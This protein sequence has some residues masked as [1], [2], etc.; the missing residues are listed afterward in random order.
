MK[1]RMLLLVA[2]ASLASHSLQAKSCN[3]IA[4][5]TKSID[6]AKKYVTKYKHNHFKDTK[7]LKNGKW[8]MISVAEENEEMA[9]KNI[10]KWKKQRKIP[11]DSKYSCKKYAEYS[12]VDLKKKPSKV[13]EN[14]VKIYPF[15]DKINVKIKEYLNE[16]NRSLST[17]KIAEKSLNDI[18][19]TP[20]NEGLKIYQQQIKKL[21]EHKNQLVL[22]YYEIYNI[23]VENKNDINKV[24]KGNLIPSFIE[25]ERSFINSIPKQISIMKSKLCSS[26]KFTCGATK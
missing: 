7:V 13:K 14:K 6:D 11:K 16:K 24:N 12:L 5:S 3:I 18:L 25:R 19:K 23:Y 15:V 20:T 26:K 9:L 2:L 4:L 1:K 8:F 10:K 21:F 17:Y 22:S